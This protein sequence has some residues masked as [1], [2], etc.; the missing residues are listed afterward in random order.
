MQL[1][2]YIMI[3]PAGPFALMNVGVTFAGLGIAM[4]MAQC[5]GFVGSLKQHVRLH[6]GILHACYGKLSQ[7]PHSDSYALSRLL[8]VSELSCRR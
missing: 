6:F 8:K 5:N 3:A 4:Q 1:A 2:G 7:S